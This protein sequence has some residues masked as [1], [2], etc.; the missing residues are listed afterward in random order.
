MPAIAPSYIYAFFALTIVASILISSFSTHMTTLKAISEIQQLENI[1]KHVATQSY[2]LITLANTANSTSKT[3]LELPL[4]IGNRQYWFR[5]CTNSSNAWVEG[6]LGTPHKS[7]V[8]HQVSLPKMV[9]ASGNYSSGYG[10]ALLESYYDGTH[11][12]SLSAWRGNT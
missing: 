12:L 3:I 1:I 5:L 8:T 10:P 7:K 4:K 11:V 6:A 2:K 9:M